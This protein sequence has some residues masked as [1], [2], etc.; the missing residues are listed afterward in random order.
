MRRLSGILCAVA[1]VCALILGMVNEQTAPVI[2][3]QR[4][5]SLTEA[6]AA[7]LPASDYIK[8]D[9]AGS[10]Y[11]AVDAGKQVLGWCLELSGKGYGGQIRLLAGIDGRGRI[12][13]IKILDHKE[14]P[15]LGTKIIEV[16]AG[17]DSPWFIRQFQGKT[18]EDMILVKGATEKNIQAITGATIS[19]QAVVSAVNHGVSEF[20]RAKQRRLPQE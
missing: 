2:A 6:L 4:E 8:K 15:G 1:V 13:A 12:T 5:R 17:E 18:H 20:L 10:Y 19:S 7:V 11:E 9:D 14:T 3:R 16:R